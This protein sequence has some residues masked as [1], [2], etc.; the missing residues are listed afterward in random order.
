VAIGRPQD[1]QL[2]MDSV[3]KIC[4]TACITE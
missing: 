1:T 4:R 3:M 2:H